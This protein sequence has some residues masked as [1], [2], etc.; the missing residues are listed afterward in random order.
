MVSTLTERYH[1]IL[2]ELS[3]ESLLTVG[4][5]MVVPVLKFNPLLAC[6]VSNLGCILASSITPFA[7]FY[8]IGII[9]LVLQAFLDHGFSVGPVVSDP[10][11]SMLLCRFAL[12]FSHI[13]R[14]GGDRCFLLFK[15]FNFVCLIVAFSDGSATF[16]I[17]LYPIA[18]LLAMAVFVIDSP[19]GNFI[20]DAGYAHTHLGIF[21]LLARVILRKKLYLFAFAARFTCGR[22]DRWVCHCAP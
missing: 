14:V 11:V 18:T 19:L 13:F 22:I 10:L 9:P 7:G 5:S 16:R 12:Y 17:S 20:F 15:V 3:L 6:E 8:Y 4:A 21:S 1:M 2:R